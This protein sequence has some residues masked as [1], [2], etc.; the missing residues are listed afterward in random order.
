MADDILIFLPKGAPYI[1]VG[2]SPSVTYQDGQIHAFDSSD[3]DELAAATRIQTAGAGFDVSTLVVAAVGLSLGGQ[4][5]FAAGSAAAPSITVTGDLDTGMFFPAANTLAWATG[6][7]ERM[8]LTD[9]GLL[10]VLGSARL[11]AATPILFIISTST[12]STSRVYFGDPDADP[13]GAFF[14]DH[15]NDSLAVWTAGAERFRIHSTGRV[16][17][18]TTAPSTS[19]HVAYSGPSSTG[20]LLERTDIANNR[21]HMIWNGDQAVIET[22]GA[23]KDIAFKQNGAQRL[24]INTAGIGIG[25]ASFGASASNVVAIANGVAPASSPAGVGQLYVESGALKYRGSSGTI[26]TLAAA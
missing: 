10:Q 18:G 7:A 9:A 6:G 8:R 19:L 26:T 2:V 24:L 23:A 21:L 13:R 5:K 25:A 11:V 20:L 4:T 3:S 1:D 22:Q 16:G 14:Y 15:S 17:I 12:S